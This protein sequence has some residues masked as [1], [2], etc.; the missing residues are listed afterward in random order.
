MIPNEIKSRDLIG[1]TVRTTVALKTGGGILVPKGTVCDM[2]SVAR[3][4]T[5]T[6]EPCK[7]YGLSLYMTGVT[8]DEVE[9]IPDIPT[10]NTEN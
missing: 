6:T 9:L 3:G 5:L 7:T 4:F 10:S 2:R 8:R 1:V